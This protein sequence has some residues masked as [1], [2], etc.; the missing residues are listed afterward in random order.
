MPT[1]KAPRP[2]GFTGIFFKVCWEIIKED[3]LLVLDSIYNLICAHLNLLN[4]ANIVLIPKKEG[5]EGVADYRPISLI[6]DILHRFG[7]AIGLVTNLQKS[8]V[9]AIRCDTIELTEVLEGVPAI[10]ANFPIKYLGL[11]LAGT[12]DITGGKCK[13][14]WKKTC[15]PTSQG[16]LGVLDLEKFTRVLR[17]R[18]LWHEWKDPTKPWVGLETPCDEIDRSLFAASTKIT[19][20]DGNMTRLW[21]SA[22]IEGQ[23]PKDLMPLVYAISKN[24]GRSLRN[25]KEEDAWVQDLALESHSPIIVELVDN[26]LPCGKRSGMS[27]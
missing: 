22:W 20:G 7:I 5:A 13:V 2:D 1:D 19:I 18:W 17:L 24:R 10:R 15:L 16:G 4:S 11:P 25:G 14:N 6:H 23:R 27:T 3:I 12:G 26:W 21:D 8:Q 9:A